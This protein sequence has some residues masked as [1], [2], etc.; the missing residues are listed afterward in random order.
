MRCDVE[1][2]VLFTMAACMLLSE[3]GR[4]CC[5]KESCMIDASDSALLLAAVRRLTPN[6]YA[7]LDLV[8]EACGMC[9]EPVESSDTLLWWERLNRTMSRLS[10]IMENLVSFDRDD[11]GI[12]ASLSMISKNG[13]CPR[14]MVS[15]RKDPVKAMR[16]RI[17]ESTL[18]R[19]NDIV[20]KG[21]PLDDVIKGVHTTVL[22]YKPGICCSEAVTERVV[23]ESGFISLENT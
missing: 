10:I 4:A 2:R 14:T 21:M 12:R 3:M 9:M 18:Y 19:T 6:S 8:E 23:A 5:Y 13:L 17:L 11:G 1:M 22:R 15:S 7:F 20:G 16:R